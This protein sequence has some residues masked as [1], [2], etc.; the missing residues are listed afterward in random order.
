MYKLFFLTLLIF[1]IKKVSYTFV[2]KLQDI[3]YVININLKSTMQ[4][5]LF[6]LLTLCIFQTA[7]SACPAGQFTNSAANDAVKGACIVCSPFC[8]TCDST[9]GACLTYNSKFKG[10]DTATLPG[11]PYCAG[12]LSISSSIGYNSITDTC[13]YCADGCINCIVDYNLCTDCK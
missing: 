2:F 1:K 10:L 8:A 3:I 5:I 7:Y 11:S 6:A 9:S 12:S 4:K 13:D